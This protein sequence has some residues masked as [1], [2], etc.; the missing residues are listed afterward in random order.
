MITDFGSHFDDKVKHADDSFHLCAGR[1]DHGTAVETARDGVAVG[2]AISTRTETQTTRH[3][4]NWRP[5]LDDSTDVT[6]QPL[7]YSTHVPARKQL[8]RLLLTL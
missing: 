6:A 3:V 5:Y 2:T 1:C 7:T 8:R 4:E